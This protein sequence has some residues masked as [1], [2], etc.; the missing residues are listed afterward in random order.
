LALLPHTQLGKKAKLSAKEKRAKAQVAKEAQRRALEEAQKDDGL[1]SSER[2]KQ[3][4]DMQK[5]ADMEHAADLFATPSSSKKGAA[6]DD[7]D[8]DFFSNADYGDDDEGGDEDDFFAS[9]DYNENQQKK[10]DDTLAAE[11]DFFGCSD[12]EGEVEVV[13][14]SLDDMKPHTEADYEEFG[15][16]LSE[17]L[18]DVAVGIPLQRGVM[19]TSGLR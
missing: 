8:D 1:T 19:R 9:A 15:D 2:R 11:Q 5:R 17:K 12:D 6:D 18:T 13:K 4:Q 14:K 3:R 16:L 7:D 10:V